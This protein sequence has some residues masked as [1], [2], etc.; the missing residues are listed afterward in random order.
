MRRYILGLGSTLAFLFVGYAVGWLSDPN[1]IDFVVGK[2]D[3]LKHAF[4]A[5]TIAS[6]FV[7]SVLFLIVWPQALLARWILRRFHFRR[8]FPLALFFG[9][10]SA[11]VCIFDFTFI[12]LHRFLA[13]LI[14]TAYLVVSCSI[15]WSI[16]F[17][18]EPVA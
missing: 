2:P 4:E 17:R 18:Y 7:I 13:Y 15:L 1:E 6:I 12:Y 14:G 10:S 16:S 8:F 9:I 3:A 5:L 11:F